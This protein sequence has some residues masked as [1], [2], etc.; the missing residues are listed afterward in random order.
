M[1]II[2]CLGENFKRKLD[3]FLHI[4]F[5]CK[6]NF[7]FQ[8]SLIWPFFPLNICVLRIIVIYFTV[9]AFLFLNIPL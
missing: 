9:N 7:R 8:K 1:L 4:V 3:Y 5:V 6:N 2:K